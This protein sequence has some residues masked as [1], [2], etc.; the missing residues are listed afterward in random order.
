MSAL[1]GGLEVRLR[2]ETLL[3]AYRTALREA[4]STD[5]ATRA[6]VTRAVFDSSKAAAAKLET[7]AEGV[8][9]VAKKFQSF[10]SSVQPE[11]IV[12]K[13][14]TAVTGAAAAMGITAGVILG[15]AVDVLR[16]LAEAGQ[17][18]GAN[19][20]AILT[21]VFAYPPLVYGLGRLFQ[22]AYESWERDR[23]E[24]Q[25]VPNQSILART[26]DPAERELYKVLGGSPPIRTLKQ[27]QYAGA[28][29]L[30]VV[31]CVVF[32]GIVVGLSSAVPVT[33]E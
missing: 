31:L 17:Q 9:D 2:A 13:T 33:T 6:A 28:V 21:R 12:G 1:D 16:A 30:G 22:S 24:A 7:R 26:V 25:T 20:P 18:V 3:N 11:D 10:T 8:D 29:V 19:A 15:I 32:A 5:I 4:D 23:R 14:Y 27:A